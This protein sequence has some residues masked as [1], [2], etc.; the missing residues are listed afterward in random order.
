MSIGHT[1]RQKLGIPINSDYAIGSGYDR[2]QTDVAVEKAENRADDVR[3]EILGVDYHKFLKNE[4]KKI[5]PNSIVPKL[6]PTVGPTIK[7]AENIDSGLGKYLNWKTG[8]GATAA[9][10][11]DLGAIHLARKLRAKKKAVNTK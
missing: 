1:L 6:N 9:I 11:A 10:G 5:D 7:N 3:K 8:L 4:P 2:P